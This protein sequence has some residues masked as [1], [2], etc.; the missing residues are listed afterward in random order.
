M[1]HS[2]ADGPRFFG[3]L[4]GCK[5][6]ILSPTSILNTIPLPVQSIDSQTSLITNILHAGTHSLS[7]RFAISSNSN[8]NSPS[9]VKSI[10]EITQIIPSSTALARSTDGA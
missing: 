5:H 8:I 7:S 4:S 6:K 9:S 10:S 3:N 1:D 2:I